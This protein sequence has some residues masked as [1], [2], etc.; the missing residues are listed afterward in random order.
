MLYGIA[1][2]DFTISRYVISSVRPIPTH[3]FLS[4]D[5][6]PS[7]GSSLTLF[8]SDAMPYALNLNNTRAN[9]SNI[10]ITNSGSQRFD[11][12]AGSFDK[13][14]QIAASPFLDAFVFIENVPF[15]VA[16]EV[17]PALNAAGADERR[18]R[19]LND[20]LEER[21]SEMWK[22]GYVDRRYMEW[23]DDMDRRN[24][25]AVKRAAQN[26]TLGY[27]TSDVSTLR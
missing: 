15:G 21:E 5:P 23:L 3:L 16:Q 9:I 7:N 22:R 6:Y 1:P 17:L 14:D 20:V 2:Q 13:N 24:D 25:G 12:Y 26:L 18:K 19:E 8:I 27:V 4:S 11:I 10:M